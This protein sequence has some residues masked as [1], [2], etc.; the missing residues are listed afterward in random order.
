MAILLKENEVASSLT[1]KDAYEALREAFLL[2]HNKMAINT[3]RVRTSFS[4]VTLTYQAGAE[5]NYLGFK[6]YLKGNFISMLFNSIGEL[7]LI[8]EA[9]RLTQVRTGALAVLASDYIKRDYSSVGIIGL[10]KQGL[11]HV[12]AFYALKPGI[13]IVAFSRSSE[14]IE[15]ANK[16]LNSEGIKVKIANSYKD[17]FQSVEVVASVTSAKDPFI[18]LEYIRDKTHVNLMGS[19]LPE[20]VEAFPEVIK[21][22]DVIVVEDVKQA[23]DEAGDL[24]LAKKMGMLDESKIVPLSS[25]IAEG[26]KKKDL[27]L[28]IF[29][30]TG[31]GLEDVAVMKRLYEKVKEMKIGREIEVKGVWSRELERK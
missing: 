29:K 28:S 15:R 11:A 12:E 23:L 16:I 8:A 21:A 30:S 27:K 13:S 7:L 6:T 19:N 18:K 17:V 9:D 22:A 31:I 20:R 3:E 5:Q 24:I 26:I 14:R 4:G 25:I 1:F 2:L 10:G